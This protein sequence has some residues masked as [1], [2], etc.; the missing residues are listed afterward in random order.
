MV[1]LSK[2]NV[3][4]EILSIKTT[5]FGKYLISHFFSVGNRGTDLALASSPLSNG[6]TF[7][8]QFDH[9]YLTVVECFGLH[10]PTEK[11]QTV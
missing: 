7:H 6:D 10:I 3:L 5:L 2:E 8:S 9:L 11:R 1:L 4:G